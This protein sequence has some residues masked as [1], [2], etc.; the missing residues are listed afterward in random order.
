ME[1]IFITIIIGFI[2]LIYAYRSGVFD[3]LIDDFIDNEMKEDN[4]EI[5]D[6]EN[7]EE[8]ED[9]GDIGW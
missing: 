1:T 5:N 3:Y 6:P 2:L 7:I 9:D 8:N 4:I